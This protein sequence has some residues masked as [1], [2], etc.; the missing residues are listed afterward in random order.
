MNKFDELSIDIKKLFENKDHL[1]NKISNSNFILKLLRRYSAA[2]LLLTKTYE[3]FINSGIFLRWFKE[4]KLYW[5]EVLHGRPLYFHDFHFLLGIYRQKFQR[6][7]T[8][9]NSS[10]KEFLD[11]WQNKDTIY[12]LFSAVRRFS[13]EPL[14]CYKYESFIKNGDKLLEYGCGIAP[15]TYSLKNYSVKRDLNFNIADIRQINSHYAKWRLGT[16][17]NFFEIKPYQNPLKDMENTFDVVF[18]ITVM[19]HLPDPL[20][21]VKNIHKSI[22]K[23]GLF[24]FDYIFSDGEAQDTIEAVRQREE[25]LEFIKTNFSIKKGNLYISKTI[26]FAVVQKN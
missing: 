14:H 18:L 4:F 25:V 9:E 5:I 7:A 10:E 16:D 3:I 2:F 8:P 11:S 6:V 13:Y 15:I 20:E 26:D 22:K 24:M 19:E 21:V 23:G 12:Q 1:N 17:A